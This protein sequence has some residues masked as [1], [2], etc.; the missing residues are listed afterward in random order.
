M[1]RPGTFK[2]ND[3]RINRN[4]RPKAFDALRKLAQQIAHEEAVSKGEPVVINGRKATVTEVILRQWFQSQDFR[5]QQAAMEIAYGKTP[6]INEHSGTDG[7]EIIFRVVR[8]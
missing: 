5:K 4:G 3:A 2:K 7:N 1:T 8:E 6:I